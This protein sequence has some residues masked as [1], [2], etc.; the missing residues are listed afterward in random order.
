MGNRLFTFIFAFFIFLSPSI[1]ICQDAPKVNYQISDFQNEINEIRDVNLKNSV[2]IAAAKKYLEK[3]SWK[4]A[5]RENPV[6]EFVDHVDILVEAVT[7]AAEANDKKFQGKLFEEILSAIELSMVKAKCAPSILSSPCE[8]NHNSTIIKNAIDRLMFLANQKSDAQSKYEIL[9]VAKQLSCLTNYGRSLFPQIELLHLDEFAPKIL[10]SLLD[11]KADVK[12]ECF[13]LENPIDEILEADFGENSKLGV[14]NLKLIAQL[15]KIHCR[16]MGEYPLDQIMSEGCGLEFGANNSLMKLSSETLSENEES[17]LRFF[18][19]SS[20]TLASLFSTDEKCY[21]LARDL[22]NTLS[23]AF[24]KIE[25]NVS[26]GDFLLNGKLGPKEIVFLS[27]LRLDKDAELALS[28]YVNDRQN[29]NESYADLFNQYGITT[30]SESS[31]FTQSSIIAGVANS[32][33]RAAIYA[34]YGT[35]KAFGGRE[36]KHQYSVKE[37]WEIIRKFGDENTA[38]QELQKYAS[39]IPKNGAIIL[40]V[41]AISSGGIIGIATNEKNEVFAQFI[42][43]PSLKTLA[44]IMDYAGSA[45]FSQTGEEIFFPMEAKYNTKS[46]GPL[47]TYILSAFMANSNDDNNFQ[48]NQLK[49]LG[50]TTNKK[51]GSKVAQM[52]KKLGIKEGSDIVIVPDF[53]TTFYPLSLSAETQGD[54]TLSEKYSLKFSTGINSIINLSHEKIEQNR[55]GVSVFVGNSKSQPLIFGEIESA[56][57]NKTINGKSSVPAVFPNFSFGTVNDSDVWHFATHG[58]FIANSPDGQG[59]VLNDE[60]T[61]NVDEIANL[62]V[63]NPPR[64]VFLSACDSAMIGLGGSKIDIFASLPAAFL[65]MGAQNVIASQ[66]RVGEFSTLLLVSKFYEEYK[67]HNMD[68]AA[69]LKAAQDWIRNLTSEEV[70]DFVSEKFDEIEMPPDIQAQLYAYATELPEN[71]KPF[72][73]PYYWAGFIIFGK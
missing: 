49:S 8:E 56:I 48:T 7:I 9:K 72:E 65:E 32:P 43:A 38:K 41:N 46:F 21:S 18:L 57:I 51:F 27:S 42:E 69:A 28:K 33:S 12:N 15:I 59:L 52:L 60:K 44:T 68:A 53:L 35:T 71:A 63:K 45:T 62:K 22:S 5:W 6:S 31:N 55:T 34:I 30:L 67:R 39:L 54:V 37:S 3:G 50:V 14:E 17:R 19:W 23:Q 10:N 11:E 24:K 16:N 4:R 13:K 2:R 20:V 70:F 29:V 61:L 58:T 25:P 73:D 66:W 1:L 40:V 64:L 26:L 36:L 47:A